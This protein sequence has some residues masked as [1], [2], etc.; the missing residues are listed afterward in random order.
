MRTPARSPRIASRASKSCHD[1]PRIT[2]RWSSSREPNFCA[3]VICREASMFHRGVPRGVLSA[4][5]EQWARDVLGLYTRRR[6]EENW[7]R[8]TPMDEMSQREWQELAD[9]IVVWTGKGSSQY[10]NRSE[11]RLA[12]HYGPEAA[13]KLLPVVE[14]LEADFYSSD[15][16]HVAADLVEMAEQASAQFRQKYPL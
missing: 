4:R 1:I 9:A 3:A 11:S 15:A 7:S 6:R 14:R 13:A 5:E 16:R 2:T 12:A 10:P 8:D